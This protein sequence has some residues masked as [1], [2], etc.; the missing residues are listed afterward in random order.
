M[1]FMRAHEEKV[2]VLALCCIRL[3]MCISFCDVHYMWL[4]MSEGLYF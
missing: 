3:F 2:I 1:C 4:S